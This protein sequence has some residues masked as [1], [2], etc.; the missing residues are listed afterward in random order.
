M[1]KQV[2]KTINKIEQFIVEHRTR[3]VKSIILKK[4]N[5]KRRIGQN[6]IHYIQMAL[7]RTKSLLE[8]SLLAVREN[9]PLLSILAIRCHFE[10]TGAISYFLLRLREHYAG[11][12]SYEDLDKSLRRL[13]LGYKIIPGKHDY[14]SNNKNEPISVMNMIDGADKISKSLDPEFSVFRK[15]YDE[16]SEY[17]HPNYLGMNL[18]SDIEKNRGYNYANVEKANKEV[19]IFLHHLVISAGMFL[20]VYD[21]IYD[22]LKSNE[23]LPEIIK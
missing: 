6:G 13:S 7:L 10:T 5:S 12:I 17:C 20:F 19:N 1:E 23:E 8:G 3:S 21:K 16:L 18:Y 15:F 9:N 22:V 11:K 4:S 2:S 14:K